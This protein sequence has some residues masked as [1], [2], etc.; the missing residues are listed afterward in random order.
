MVFASLRLTIGRTFHFTVLFLFSEMGLVLPDC[1]VMNT[2][3]LLSHTEQEVRKLD[4]QEEG[5]VVHLPAHV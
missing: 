2:D 5:K 1:N 4:F 3:V